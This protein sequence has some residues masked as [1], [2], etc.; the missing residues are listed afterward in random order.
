MNDRAPTTPTLLLKA[1]DA[2]KALAIS[3]RKLW[4]LTNRGDIPAVHICRT[5]RYDPADLRAWIDA[6]RGPGARQ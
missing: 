3:P 4:E 5:V 1:D 6:R 2:A